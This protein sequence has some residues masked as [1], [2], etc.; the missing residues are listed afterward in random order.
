[1]LWILRIWRII[2]LSDC[3]LYRET[4][5]HSLVDVEK[6]VRGSDVLA[7]LQGHMM[8]REGWAVS[9][10][11]SGM[12]FEARVE[13]WTGFRQVSRKNVEDEKIKIEDRHQRGRAVV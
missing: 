13:C 5:P 7:G 12:V 8:R 2:S 6:E 9:C 1:M 3:A 10:Y 4:Q 11:E